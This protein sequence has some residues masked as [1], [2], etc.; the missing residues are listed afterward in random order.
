MNIVSFQFLRDIETELSRISKV[1]SS[2]ARGFARSILSI[3]IGLCLTWPCAAQDPNPQS[4]FAPTV[5]LANPS[6]YLNFNDQTTSFKDV[7]TGSSF[8]NTEQT[9]T[10]SGTPLTIPNGQTIAGDFNGTDNYVH[11]T[12]ALS[13]NSVFSYAGCVYLPSSSLSGCFFSNGIS[14]LSGDGGSSGVWV[15]VGS[16]SG[17]PGTGNYLIVLSSAVA[18]QQTG[19]AIGTGWHFIAVTRDGTTMRAYIDG[20]QTPTLTA[21]TATPIAPNGGVWMGQTS[22]VGGDKMPFFHGYLSAW[23]MYSVALSQSQIA[24]LMAGGTPPSGLVGQWELNGTTL[25]SSGNGNSGTWNGTASGDVGYYEGGTTYTYYNSGTVTPRQP[26]FDSTLL[27]NTSAEFPWNGWSAAPNNTLGAIE[28][29]TPWSMMVQVDRLNWNR[30]GTLVL[31]SKGDLASGSSWALYLQMTANAMPG[32][33]GQVSQLCFSRTS[34]ASGSAVYGVAANGICTSST[35]EA[36]PNGFNYNIIVTNSGTG[37]S[38]LYSTTSALDIYINGLDKTTNLPETPFTGSYQ[39]GFGDV[40]VT[41]SGGTG[42]AN[43]TAFTSSGGG[44]NCNVAGTMD[45]TGGVPNQSY[46]TVSYT[47]DYGCTSV[48]TITLTAPTGTG[49]TLTPTLAGTTMNSTSY[50]LMVPGYVSNGAYYGIAGA[51]SNQTPTYIDEFAIFPTSLNQT[52]INDIFYWTKFYQT[53]ANIRPANPPVVL[54]DTDGCTDIANADGLE[55]AIVMHQLGL[56]KIEGVITSNLGNGHDIYDISG[57]LF[58]QMLDQ[59]GL[60]N[61]PVGVTYPG[62]GSYDSTWCTGSNLNAY[63]ASTLQ[64]SAGFPASTVVARTVLANNPTTPVIIYNGSA[65][66][67]NWLSAFLQSP[68]DS[69]SSLTGQQLWDRDVANGGAMWWQGPPS[70]TATSYP[71][72]PMVPCASSWGN[73]ALDAVATQYVWNH[74]DG[75]PTY[76]AESTPQGYGSGLPFTRTAKDPMYLACDVDVILLGNCGRAGWGQ[77]SLASLFSSYF[78]GG[79]AVSYSGGT[80]YANLTPFT[81]TGGG[82]N[83]VV[84]GIM[85]ASGGVPNGIETFYGVPLPLI[86]VDGLNVGIGSGCTSAPTLVLTSPTGTGVTLTAYPTTVC[87]TGSVSGSTFSFSSA[88]CSNQYAVPFTQW[89]NVGAPYI[90]NWFLDSL[91]DPPTNGRPRR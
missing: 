31:A 70:C 65:P 68:A 66:A 37:A 23:S 13:S 90:Y 16:A 49:V 28:W 4:G 29:N 63:N 77:Y 51:T 82:A 36:M 87:G 80:G 41:Y 39:Y 74:L 40:S 79:V 57:P 9:G 67:N 52:Q 50:P 84:N 86:S 21:S 59:A 19:A 69:I 44:A 11:A 26:G 76:Q 54:Y 2:F 60:A 32:A 46:P 47:F 73:A 53:L 38:G 88:T 34:P 56:L 25:D 33:N 35:L 1:E 14:T 15:G 30:T 43:T 48:P 85:T 3:L 89:A 24:A 58:R 62:S 10:L 83:C 42:Y 45:A 27:N 91:A 71:N 55:F 6:T 7:V 81:S 78:T 18:W 20:T 8:V 64:T 22:T 72:P 5:L 75:M 61:I 12:S 17:T